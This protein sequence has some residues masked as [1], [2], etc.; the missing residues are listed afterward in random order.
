MPE[1]KN[2]SS[3]EVAKKLEQAKAIAP[4]LIE[5]ERYQMAINEIN[6]LQNQLDEILGN[7]DP[8]DWEKTIYGGYPWHADEDG[9]TVRVFCENLQVFK[10]PKKGTQYE[11][12]WPNPD[13]L[14]WMLKVLNKAES[15]G[16]VSP[17]AAIF[18]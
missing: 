3:N 5:K 9:S 18:R 10:A 12:Y 1:I 6:R 2:E 13:L 15:S 17:P 4:Y 11:E 8:A 16:D 7:D 14:K